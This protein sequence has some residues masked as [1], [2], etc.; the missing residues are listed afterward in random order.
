MP[1]HF[2]PQQ[3]R[4]LLAFFDDKAIWTIDDLAELSG[5]KHSLISAILCK[6]ER[7]GAVCWERNE[8]IKQVKF[9]SEVS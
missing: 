6:L 9:W 2:T 5:F 4:Y 1:H 7:Q 8:D 3:E